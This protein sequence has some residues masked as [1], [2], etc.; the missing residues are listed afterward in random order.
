ME[1]PPIL[2]VED[3]TD[4]S[5]MLIDLLARHGYAGVPAY[6]GTEALLLADMQTFSLILLD[7][8]LPGKNGGEVLTQLRG[9]GIVT[10]VIAVSA[11][12]ATPTKVEL[13]Q[14]GAEDYITKPFDND[15]LIARIQVQ[16][17]RQEGAEAAALRQGSLRLDPESLTVTAAGQPVSLTKRELMILRL[18][19]ENPHKVFTRANIYES[20]WGEDFFGDDSTVNVHISNLRTKLGRANPGSEYIQ[21]VWGIGFKLAENL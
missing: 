8:M 7:L 12:T 1:Q 6:S 21:T 11:M 13:L 9:K 14:M 18:L 20:V 3:D 4:I 2:V 15:E 17:R 5:N 19:L 10:P 16:L